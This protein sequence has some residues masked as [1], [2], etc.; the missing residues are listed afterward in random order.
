MLRLLPEACLGEAY[1]MTDAIVDAFLS[2]PN[3]CTLEGMNR[4]EA[5][6][7]EKLFQQV[8]REP[9]RTLAQKWPFNRWLEAMRESLRLTRDDIAIALKKDRAFV[10]RLENGDQEP[11]RF[12]P[13][14]VCDIVYL[15]RIHID[16]VIDLVA[17]SAAVY[18]SSGV[19][20]IARAHR[21]RTSEARGR[22]TK[23]AL[24]LY[25]ARNLPTVQLGDDISSWLDDLRRELRNR[26][27]EELL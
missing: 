16:V 17:N 7:V 21:G 8:H 10:E 2:V 5:R 11:W 22:S 24:E 12:R 26:K 15:F 25:L 18:S 20:A 3:D 23:R 13:G 14:D 9:V 1:E 6:F 4:I 27:L 19:E